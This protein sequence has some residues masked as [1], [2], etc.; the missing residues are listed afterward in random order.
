VPLLPSADSSALISVD[1]L[2]P[3]LVAPVELEPLLAA[4]SALSSWLSPPLSKLLESVLLLGSVP[5]SAESRTESAL[6]PSC[7]CAWARASENDAPL[8]ALEESLEPVFELVPV[9]AVPEDWVAA[10]G[11]DSCC[12]H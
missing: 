3:E 1:E 7:D 10:A 8:L 2:E 11:F 4:C 6:V 12:S 9:A 5:L